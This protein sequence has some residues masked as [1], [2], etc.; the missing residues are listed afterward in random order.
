MSEQIN[1]LIT[2]PLDDKLIE[3]LISVSPKLNLMN[4][5]ANRVDEISKES[6]EA[7]HILYTNR[8]I[9]QPEQ[10]PNLEWIQFHWAGI[11]HALQAPILSRPNMKLTTLSGA[12]CSQVAEYIVMM[13]L[14]LGHRFPEMRAAQRRSEWP[15][16]RWQRFSPVELR[17]ST[18]GIIGY[19]SIGRQTARL[20]QV[21]GAK[22]LAAKH[23]AM[24]TTDEGYTLEGMGDPQGEIPLR[25]YPP[26][27]L[28]TMVREC[29]F[30][31]VTAPYTHESKNLV[32]AEVLQACKSG[33]YLVHTSRAGVLD[34]EALVSALKSGKLAGAA[35]DVFDEEPLPAESP[36]WKAPNLIISPHISGNSPEYDQRAVDL[37]AENLRRYL[38]KLP[39]LNLFDMNLG[40]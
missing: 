4:E 13:L 36:L 23:N 33:A 20:L 10:A 35:L 2:L 24:K 31:V 8:V 29:D 3:K 15:Q 9:P 40:Y 14:A 21:F 16:D 37:F 32:D 38:I 34:Q 12:A 22:I 17:G 26:Q 28:K 30:V 25:I 39:L 5:P 1:V 27:A 19:G 18:V 7:A 11:N 6:W